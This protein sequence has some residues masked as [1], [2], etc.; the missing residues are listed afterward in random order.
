[1]HGQ[2]KQKEKLFVVNKSGTL[3]VISRVREEASQI[4]SNHTEQFWWVINRWW[5]HRCTF[6]LLLGPSKSL[7]FPGLGTLA[8]QHTTEKSAYLKSG[9]TNTIC[10][11]TICLNQLAALFDKLGKKIPDIFSTTEA[12]IHNITLIYKIDFYNKYI[13]LQILHWLQNV[14]PI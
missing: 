7:L 4:L 2:E 5:R 1:M 12:Q 13:F 14:N 11:H 10:P 8:S 6:V 3:S 9:I